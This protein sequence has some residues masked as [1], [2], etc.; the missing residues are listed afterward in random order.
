MQ[1]ARRDERPDFLELALTSSTVYIDI[2]GAQQQRERLPPARRAAC[3][4]RGAHGVVLVVAR[5]RAGPWTRRARAPA[6][7]ARR[8][9]RRSA[10][11]VPHTTRPPTRSTPRGASQPRPAVPLPSSA[12]RL[13][14]VTSRSLTTQ[15]SPVAPPLHT[16]APTR[17]RSFSQHTVPQHPTTQHSPPLH[18][19]CPFLC[20][21]PRGGRTLLLGATAP[22]P[23]LSCVMC[24]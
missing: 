24:A 23:F 20:V 10:R 5:T 7:S 18:P 17:R 15:H 21:P 12:L 11:A 3:V 14:R 4:G 13:S 16:P 22:C 6:R 9:G 19:S 2:P 8:R 1:L